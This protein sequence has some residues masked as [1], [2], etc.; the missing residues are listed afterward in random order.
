MHRWLA[1]L[2]AA[3]IPAWYAEQVFASQEKT[4][5]GNKPA[6]ANDKLNVGVI[7]VG[8]RPRRSNDLYA[9]AKKF[10]HVNFNAVCDVDGRHLDYAVEQYKKDKYE[11]KGYKD[12]RQLMD[13]K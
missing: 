5:A 9:G 8:P 6:G 11:V 1:G 12:Y 10:K 3:G 7:G 4:A 2:A 13:N